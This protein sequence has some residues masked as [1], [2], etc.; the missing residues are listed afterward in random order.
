MTKSIQNVRKSLET[1]TINNTFAANVLLNGITMKRI[2][3]LLLSSLLLTITV[4]ANPIDPE[5]AGEI[6]NNFWN[7]KVQ[8]AN[9][10]HLIM[11]SPTKMAKAG[12]RINI[13][14]S[15]P[16][17]YIY[18]PDNNKGFVIV[19]G[20]DALAPVIG[21]STEYTGENS[22]MPAALVEWLNEYSMYVDDVRAG[23]AAPAE[24]AAKADKTAIAPMLQTSWDQS[25][26]Y[27]NLCPEV[28]GQ[29]TP[30]GCTATAMAQ[31]MKFH[32]WPITPIKSISWTSNITGKKET[33]DL[34]KRTYNWDNMLP[35]YRN[36]YTAAQA[37]E[38]AQ[39]MV[40]VG[41]AIQSSYSPSGTGSSAVYASYALVNTFD[42]SPDAKVVNRSEYT[43]EE[44]I[45]I[46][47]ENLEARQP[48]LYTGH[49][50]SYSS[51]H[52][53]V[54]DGIDENDLLHI[55]WGWSGA[56]NGYFDMTYMSPEGTGIGGGD[57]RYNVS[58]A[59]IAYIHPRGKD[60]P[61]TAGTPV[62]YIMDVVDA[63]ASGTPP[64]LLEQTVEYDNKGVATTR[65]A[66]GLLNWSH[67]NI[68]MTMYIGVEKDGKTNFEKIGDPKVTP[69][70][71]DMG[72]YIYLT[73]SKNQQ[74][75]EYLEKGTYKVK[76][77]YSDDNGE[78][79]YVARGADNGLI[80]EV[81]DNSVTLRKE[82]PEVEVTD[83]K[84]HTTPQMKGDRLA[85]DAE[86]RTNN[87]K[88][89]TVL[90]VPVIN[91]LQS[92]N[93][94]SSTQL[95]SEAALIQVYDDRDILASFSTSY[96]FPDNGKYFI[97]FK[98]N[99]KN[100]YTDSSMDVD[101]ATLQDIAGRSNDIDISPLPEGLV[102]STT[103]LSASAITY[104]E[105]ANITATVKNISTSDD[106]FTG[107]LALFA[108]DNATGKSYLLTSIH[109]DNMEKGATTNISYR[110]P[111]YLPVM[112]PGEHTISIRQAD[113]GRWKEI[114]QS[115]ATCIFD[116]APTTATIPYING[117]MDINN[118]NDVIVQ[119]NEFV[120]NATLGC[121]NADFD[122]YV[123]VNVPFGVHYLVRSEHI[124]VSIKKDGTANVTIPCKTKA[125]DNFDRYRL[126]I[127]YYD[128][129]KTKLGDM[130][131]NTLTYSGNGYFWIGDGT[132]IEEVE[133]IGNAI[134]TLNGNT[135]T[136]ANAEDAIVT[137]Y[138]TDGREV[139]KGTDNSIQVARGM[140]IVTV[141]QGGTTTA[142][143]VFVK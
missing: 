141:Q 65:F 21:Y 84:Y 113:N 1:L 115:A 17:Y 93:T 59:V 78:N 45:S 114:R 66:A 36:G 71:E 121:L 33:I 67:S 62:V 54:C 104:G 27:N 107:R 101:K 140:Y 46:I 94:Y 122:G 69:F 49:S 11:H 37:Q 77:C 89:A 118:G 95:T 137:V 61:D 103:D 70:N 132:A 26:P 53:F 139:Y 123:R 116:I 74:D 85:F 35:H 110:T 3:T 129:K 108:K 52:A 4:F 25:A 119:G 99:I 117:V 44:Y 127:I 112:Q 55:D 72:Y 47:R 96:I 75:K 111:D 8:H 14:E 105:K 60:E 68:N 42:Y 48:L 106:T 18:T 126:S 97:S 109:V 16:Q 90:I 51:G 143:K 2:A 133:E 9:T 32:E 138:S 19:S 73:A 6:A 39:L 124:P 5:K 81:G 31:I 13:Q 41:K 43:E 24:R 30:T 76:V 12:S 40:D 92:D 38:V 98:Y 34:T 87:G 64:T 128:S 136:I 20:D 135:I 79:I 86:F 57:G 29:K 80:L 63:T 10:E 28:N 134:I 125:N 131:N 88:S 102:L 100:Q 50:Q 58:Q 15:N 56:F 7:S 91:K 22:E 83:I 82:L 142:T 23:K 120:V 130:S